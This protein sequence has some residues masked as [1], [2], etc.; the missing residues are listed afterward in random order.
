VAALFPPGVVAVEL[1]GEADPALLHPD[2]RQVV[3][4]VA[5]RRLKDYA[6]GRE[7]ARLAL[8]QLEIEDFALLPASDRQ[9]LWPPQITGS[10]THTHGY[11]IAVAARRSQVG[12][13]GIDAELAQAVHEELWPRI[14]RP[15]ELEW[16]ARQNT[17]DR[18]RLAALIFAAKESFYKCQYPLTGEWLGF[19]EVLIELTG[20]SQLLVRPQRPIRLEAHAPLPVKGGFRFHENWVTAGIAVP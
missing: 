8:R 9:P 12:G 19:E 13:L 7:C 14:C 6:A 17:Q 2:E 20:D 15:E 11:C 5:A 10:I 18:G 16:L 4:R 3:E 1:V